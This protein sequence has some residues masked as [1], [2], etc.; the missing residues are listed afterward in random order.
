MD[1]K[2]TNLIIKMIFN[3]SNEDFIIE[4][5]CSYPINFDQPV[6]EDGTTLLILAVKNGMITVSMNMIRRQAD[7]NKSDCN[8]NT[9]LHHAFMLGFKDCIDTLI[10][11]G[12]DESIEN[13]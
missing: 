2:T 5:L 9:P 6:F 10:E 13:N 12:A 1:Q 11:N 4:A 7:I 3:Q 8:G